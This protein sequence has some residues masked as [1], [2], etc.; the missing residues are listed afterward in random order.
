MGTFGGA[1]GLS[2]SDFWIHFKVRCIGH[3]QGRGV[4]KG[5][6]SLGNP[7]PVWSAHPLACLGARKM[8]KKNKS[9]CRGSPLRLGAGKKGKVGHFRT[10]HLNHRYH[11]GWTFTVCDLLTPR[12]HSAGGPT[13]VLTFPARTP[14]LACHKV[15]TCHCLVHTRPSSDGGDKSLIKAGII[16][17]GMA[18][19][20]PCDLQDP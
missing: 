4:W 18:L 12:F 9:Q 10:M 17:V 20:H 16:R 14:I 8:G 7:A 5:S 15:V 6:W 2:V 11:R 19:T 3:P 1:K 13:L